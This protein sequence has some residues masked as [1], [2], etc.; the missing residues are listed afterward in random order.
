[1]SNEELVKELDTRFGTYATFQFCQM[2]SYVH[3]REF[4]SN[5]ENHLED[6]CSNEW[7]SEWWYNEFIKRFNAN[8]DN[9]YGR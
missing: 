4:E 8:K 6:V 2:N 1:M 9:L 5:Q 7:N 3:K